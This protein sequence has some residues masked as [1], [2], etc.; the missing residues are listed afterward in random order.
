M[1]MG[2]D[3]YKADRDVRIPS[4]KELHLVGKKVM[5]H[6]IKLPLNALAGFAFHSF[7]F[8]RTPFSTGAFVLQRRNAEP[9]THPYWYGQ[10]INVRINV[11]EIT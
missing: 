10:V 7:S 2:I 8:P 1:N 9:M 6:C 4:R 3:A 5:H 11:I